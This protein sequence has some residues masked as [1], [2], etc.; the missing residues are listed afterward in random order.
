VNDET[1]LV[2]PPNMRR[3]LM[4]VAIGWVLIG[5]LGACLAG[6]DLVPD[7]RAARG[8]GVTGTLVLTEPNGCDRF[9]PPKQRCGWLGK[10][11]S[12]DGK[13]V[14]DDV[15]L[16]EGLP[17]GAHAGDTVVVR[18]VGNPNV[19]YQ[20]NDRDTWQLTAVFF[21]GFFAAFLIGLLLLQPWTWRSRLQ[22]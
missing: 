17:P 13:I 14:R 3:R 19:V 22:R 21:A 2:K 11:R 1:G 7:V 4:A 8:D 6:I 9:P 16:S 10:F 5:A 20:A 18:D 12:D 15:E